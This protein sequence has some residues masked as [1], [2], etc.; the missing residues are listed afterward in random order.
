MKYR[1]GLDL[2]STS[3]GWCVLELDSNGDIKNIKDAGVRIFPDGRDDKTKVPLSVNRRE[4][5][6]QRRNRDRYLKR[7][8]RLIESLVKFGLM[9]S[10]IEKRKELIKL[11]PYE[12]RAK[13]IKE[14]LSLYELGRALFHIN[15]RRG[16]KSNRKYDITDKDEKGKILTASQKLKDKIAEYGCKTIGEFL[17][18]RYKN[19]ETV[20]VKMK[21]GQ[22]DFY[23]L[24][25]MYEKE[26]DIIFKKQIEFYPEILE[27]AEKEIKEII[28]FQRDLLPQEKGYCEFEKNE[29]RIAKA[30]P[31]FQEF[32]I[33]QDVNNLDTDGRMGEYLS[34]EQK[35]KIKQI[36]NNCE[37]APNKN[38]FEISFSK[39]K[40]QIGLNKNVKFNFESDKRKGLKCNTTNFLLSSEDCF[41][42]EWYKLNDEKRAEVVEW[43]ISDKKDFEIKNYLKKEFNFDDSKS[44]KVMGTILEDGYASLSKKAIEKILPYLKQ[45]K[46]YSEACKNAGYHHSDHKPDKILPN[47]PY[48]GEVLSNKVMRDN[49]NCNDTDSPEKK[50]GKINNPSVHIALNQLRKVINALIKK[51]GHPDEISIEMARDLKL[52]T[53]ALEEIKKEQEKNQKDNERIDEILKRNKL[54]VNPENR[55]RY[56]LWE[57]LSDKPQY[58]QCVYTGKQISVKDI[59]TDKFEIDH[60]LPFSRTY[61][62]AR[63]NKILISREANRV[64][65]NMTP[66]EA[67]GK[68]D[69]WPEILKRI[70]RLPDNKKW[71]FGE[72]A[73]KRYEQEGGIIARLLNDTRYM[74]RVAK[75]YLSFICAPNKIDVPPG[76]LTAILRNVWGL[77]FLKDKNKTK[78]YRMD[79]RHHAIDAFIIGCTTKSMLQKAAQC[80]EK[81]EEMGGHFKG[82]IKL[83]KGKFLPFE[84][85]NKNIRESFKKMIDNI[86]V[87][88]KPDHKDVQKAIS[89]YSTIGP[90]HEATA[91]GPTNLKSKK[92]GYIIVSIRR[93]LKDINEKDL[94]N[95]A[96]KGIAKELKEILKIKDIDKRKKLLEKYSKDNNI[97]KVTCY[98]EKDE[99]VLIPIYKKKSDGTYYEKPYKY[100][101]GGNNY[102]IDI[103][104]LRPDDKREPE[105]AG[106]WKGEVISNYNAHKPNFEPKWRKEHPTAK[107]IMRL[108]INDM[109]VLT[110]N[111]KDKNDFPKNIKNFI[112]E[113]FN[114]TKKNEVDMVFRIKKISTNGTFFI[115]PHF[116]VKDEKDKFSWGASVS[117]IF[118]YK[119]RKVYVDELGKIIDN[120]F[121]QGW[122]KNVKCVRNK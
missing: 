87:S 113:E 81:A 92:P 46:I 88:Y 82:R 36:L 32:R 53:K 60:I 80:S 63:S 64:K 65:G 119:A 8:Q 10:D 50:Y 52:G 111:K 85:F 89:N 117:G 105:K 100:Y 49:K 30:H 4:A 14:K 2:G 57:E 68:T 61:D 12:L 35:N 21:D 47:L 106:K 5:R 29:K 33:E 51:Y 66:F 99:N 91:Y 9:P 102:C 56:K 37:I 38:N 31:L 13:A 59:W 69:K 77:N 94:D 112:L 71:R 79:H 95:I 15:Q 74:A 70:E 97:K 42:E 16:F 44:E 1:L 54:P 72:N 86:I 17:W 73:M 93:D 62:D 78:S 40:T 90:L 58:R 107:R 45:G 28:F 115:T 109:I 11:N 120:G 43:L 19:G 104:C 18:K 6:G 26:V 25:E 110:F 75:E 22:Y 24:R 3:L 84:G 118:I 34:E 116:I 23:P 122:E 7:R 39:I 27:K 114:K 67:F 83:F 55:L 103:I 41:G 96:D 20:R 108:F 98:E 101:I 48:Y 121:I 76:Q